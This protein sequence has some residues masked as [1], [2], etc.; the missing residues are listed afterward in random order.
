MAALVTRRIFAIATDT[1]GCY[2]YRLYWPLTNLNPD[3]FQLHWGGP[4][5]DRQAGDVVIG[6]RL[7]GDNAAWTHL[8]GDP[9]ILAVYEIDDD[10]V[11]VDPDN[12]VPYQI[13]QPHR[14]GTIRNIAA[15]DVVTCSTPNLAE[16]IAARWNPNVVVLPNCL[17]RAWLDRPE[18]RRGDGLLTV[19]WAGSMFHHQDWIGGTG[20]R[21]NQAQAYNPR[22][23]FAAIG[24]DYLS[25][26]VSVEKFTG[27]NSM[28]AYLA[29]LDFDIGLAPLVRTEFNQSK[30]W[31]K[32]LEYGAR[33]I[34][35]VA[36]AWGQ[37]PQW[38][39]LL[40]G[41]PP[42]VLVD[43]WVG[44][45]EEPPAVPTAL[46]VLCD[47]ATRAT[48]GA[49]AKARARMFTIEANAQRWAEVYRR[50]P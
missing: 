36:T 48:M 16:K 23:R 25:P 37:Y 29:A 22:I 46:G 7:A 20:V 3:E 24:A 17:P 31:A 15:A 6:Q 5:V 9:T 43:D 50:Q 39:D 21:L 40:P 13:F 14:D 42:G 18:Q 8:C 35:A 4:A 41:D 12:T 19:G 1:A 33:G 27:W 38:F 34:P 44:G 26:H 49:A 11:D 47:D 30:S 2:L 10:I 45:F 32:L 28:D